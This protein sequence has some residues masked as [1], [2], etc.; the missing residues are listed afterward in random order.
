MD[1]MKKKER[2]KKELQNTRGENTQEEKKRKENDTEQRK[3]PPANHVYIRT[4]LV[5]SNFVRNTNKNNENGDAFFLS[6]SLLNHLP[7]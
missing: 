2:K 6:N 1:K 4:R 5:S 7:V 3:R